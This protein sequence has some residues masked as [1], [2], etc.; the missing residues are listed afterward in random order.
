MLALILVTAALAADPQPTS[1]WDPAEAEQVQLELIEVL[2]DSKQPDKALYAITQVRAGGVTGSALDILQARALVAKGLPMDAVLLLEDQYMRDFQRHKV[3]CLAHMD[4]KETD[5]A[6]LNCRKALRFAP[7]SLSSIDVADLHNNLGFVLASQN[8][9]EEAILSYREALKLSPNLARARN[10]MGFSQAALGQDEK[11]LDT[12]RAAL[13][14]SLGF[15][16]EI[17]EAEAYFNLGVAQ[18][19]RGADQRAK[20]SFHSALKHVPGHAKARD[21]LDQMTPNLKEAP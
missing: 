5:E 6:E 17:L 9:H 11:A 15:D 1:T 8:R 12:F 10:N 14:V 2:I 7:S 20:D 21:A 19:A 18:L 13:S 4:L 16:P 3:V